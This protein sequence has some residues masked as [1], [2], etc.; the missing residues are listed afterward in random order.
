MHLSK[1]LELS[2]VLQEGKQGMHSLFFIYEFL[3]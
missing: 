2:Q 1:R 3:S